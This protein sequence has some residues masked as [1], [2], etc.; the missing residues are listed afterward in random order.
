MAGVVKVTYLANGGVAVVTLSSPETLNALDHSILQ[1]LLESVDAIAQGSARVL[2]LTAEG[3]V[4]A[5]FMR[6]PRVVYQS[7]PSSTAR[8]PSSRAPRRAVLPWRIAD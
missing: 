4:R 8:A 2:V 6:C 1:G 7:L 5:A 3:T